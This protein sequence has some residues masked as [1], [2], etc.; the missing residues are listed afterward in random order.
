MFD[1][2]KEIFKLFLFIIR[3]GHKENFFDIIP[4]FVVLSLIYRKI[5][6]VVF[7]AFT[8]QDINNFPFIFNGG[9]DSEN[10]IIPYGKP[11]N[12]FPIITLVQ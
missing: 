5:F 7:F 1:F 10:D 3:Q 12:A 6:P 9:S 2:S 11:R 8:I 4:A